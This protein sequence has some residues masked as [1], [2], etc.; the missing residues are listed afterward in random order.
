MR[1]AAA[2]TFS[3]PRTAA[4][5]RSGRPWFSKRRSARSSARCAG[6]SRSTASPSCSSRA[7]GSEVLATAGEGAKKVFPPGSVEADRRLDLRDH[8]DAAAPSTGA[9]CSTS[10]IPRRRAA[11]ARASLAARG[12]AARRLD[13]V[14][15][16]SFAR[17]E[18]D[19]FS[20]GGGR[21]RLAHRPARC[22]RRAEHPRVRRRAPHRRG[23]T[24]PLR[25][26]RGLRLARLARAAQPD[27]GRHRRRADAAAALARAVAGAARLVPRPDRRRDEPARRAHRRRARHVSHRGGHVHLSGSRTST[28]ASS[29]GSG[30]FGGCSGR[31]RCRSTRSCTGRS[32]TSAATACACVR[33]SPNLI[34][35]AVKWSQ[36]G[37]PVDVE[38]TTTNGRVTVGVSRPRARASRERSTASSSRS[39]AARRAASAGRAPGSGSSSR[40]R[41]PKR[42]AERSTSVR[43]RARGDVHPDPAGVRSESAAG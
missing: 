23:A 32:R 10:T 9:T 25:A 5:A 33:F 8:L 26:A 43:H 20:V 30:R 7:T 22:D 34:E 14:G 11:R 3:R 4:P 35:N 6:S 42:T 19:A 15:L 31:T 18:P 36:G 29:P 40:A 21:A 39:S 38:V 13:A 28:S 17:R 1:S 2:S 37:E 16:I 24:P 12:A 41:S 27:G